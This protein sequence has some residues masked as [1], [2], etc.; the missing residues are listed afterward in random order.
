MLKL[1]VI[2]N[3]VAD[4]RI[5][6]QNGQQVG[7]ARVAGHTPFRDANNEYITNFIN[8]S[9]WGKASETLARMHKGDKVAVT[10]NFC[11]KLYKDK[12]GGQQIDITCRAETIESLAPKKTE[13]Q[14]DIFT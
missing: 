5:G 7:N 9:V 13:Q 11:V 10:G 14:D 12:N 8:V 6:E 3:L 2:G 1:V 4:P